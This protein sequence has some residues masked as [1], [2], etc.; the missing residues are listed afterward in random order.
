MA[1]WTPMENSKLWNI[2]QEKKQSHP[3]MRMKMKTMKFQLQGICLDSPNPLHPSHFLHSEEATNILQLKHNPRK[4]QGMRKRM[5]MMSPAM[6][7]H[8]QTLTMANT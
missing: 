5:T 4:C 6:T 1:T 8:Q 7:P 2:Q 3:K